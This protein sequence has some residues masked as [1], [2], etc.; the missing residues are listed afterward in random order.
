[1]ARYFEFMQNHPIL[2]GLFLALLVLFFV[3]DSKRGGKKVSPSQVG[4]MTNE[5]AKLIDIRESKEY[6]QGHIAGSRNI[7]YSR[8]ND[9]I[10]ELKAIP[11]PIIIICKIGANAASAIAKLE[12]HTAFRLDGGIM[13]WQS[14]GLPLVTAKDES[15]TKK[16]K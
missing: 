10:D 12:P 7:P 5:G 4:I 16:R 11:E 1:M 2:V 8:L 3:L 9:H 14:Q 15:K 13:N 6:K